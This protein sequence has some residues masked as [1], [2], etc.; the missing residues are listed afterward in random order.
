MRET[1]MGLAD[2]GDL[3][4]TCT[5]DQSRNRRFGMALGQG[6]SVSDAQS[7]IHQVVEGLPAARAVYDVAQRLAVDM[8]ICQEV[9]RIMHEDKPVRAAVQALMGRE[10]RAE[11]E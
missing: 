3:V 5:D 9:Y 4:L 6:H 8:P 2:L 1:F 10:M 11:T 7:G